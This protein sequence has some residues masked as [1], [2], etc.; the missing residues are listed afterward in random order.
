MN[1]SPWKKVLPG[2][3][4]QN[5]Q[6]FSG[7]M[8]C[9]RWLFFIHELC[10]SPNTSVLPF[11][12][13]NY[14]GKLIKN[15]SQTLTTCNN[16]LASIRLLF[17]AIVTSTTFSRA[18]DMPYNWIYWQNFRTYLKG[19][20]T[21]FRYFIVTVCNFK[22]IYLKIIDVG[23]SNFVIKRIQPP[24]YSVYVYLLQPNLKKRFFASFFIIH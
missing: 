19:H 14:I 23:K 6:L 4:H 18:F 5:Y 8:S 22:S 3:I 11:Y 2:T 24:Q 13:I 10:L 16:M 17:S 12:H 15:N 7:I 21:Y 1:L 9:Q 20:I